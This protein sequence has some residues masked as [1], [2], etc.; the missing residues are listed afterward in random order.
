MSAG[1]A[2]LEAVSDGFVG[3]VEGVFANGFYVSGPSQ[4]ILCVLGPGSWA[5]PLHLVASELPA[6]PDLHDCV[7]VSGGVL[8]AGRLL[9]RVDGCPHWSPRLP[10]K[11]N[12][13][14]A[15]WRSVAAVV[16][17]ELAP[18]FGRGDPVGADHRVSAVV[19]PELAPVFGCGDP[20]GVD[21]RVS[22]VVDPEL[23]PVWAAATDD[24]RRGDLAAVFRRLQG[25][26]A[27]L[28]PSGDD[29]LAGALLVC[30]INPR[31]RPALD[32]LARSARTTRLSRAFLRWAAA[33]QS[34]EPAHAL[35]DAAAADDLAAMRAAAR[36]LA[37]VGATS[38]KAL[39]AGIALAATQLPSSQRPSGWAAGR[40][41]FAWL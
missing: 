32:G 22:A 25:R 6:R 38:G 28:T 13:G 36:S 24:M 20:V 2:V 39:V 30:A 4:A 23:A 15:T 27:G 29:V 41:D 5:G 3:R 14:S 9:V 12:I 21:H 19:D 7:S 1:E 40:E 31:R 34:I 8:E 16:D 26:G 18:V 11:L 35:L 17:P 33:G 37:Q 10:E